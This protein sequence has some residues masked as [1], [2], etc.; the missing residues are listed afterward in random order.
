MSQEEQQQEVQEVEAIEY[1]PYTDDQ[2]IEW[3]SRQ[4]YDIAQSQAKYLASLPALNPFGM[5]DDAK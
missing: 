3:D 1:K 4:D 5:P 2:G